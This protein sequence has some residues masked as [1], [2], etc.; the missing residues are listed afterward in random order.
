MHRLFDT[1]N[2]R[3][4]VEIGGLWDFEAEGRQ[5]VMPVPA[6]WETHPEFRN[7]R[8]KAIYKTG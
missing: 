4:S 3:R 7:F 6:C 5:A 2:I 1:H 8:G